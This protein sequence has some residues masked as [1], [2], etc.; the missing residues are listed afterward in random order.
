[1]AAAD[2]EAI[3]SPIAQMERELH[4]LE[5]DI[6][7]QPDGVRD[8]L[9][10]LLTQVRHDW[11]AT[12]EALDRTASAAREDLSTLRADLAI[13]RADLA[14]EMSE[15]REG[16]R[17]ALGDLVESWRAR[18]DHAKV[19]AELGRL[20]A[21]DEVNDDL[22]RAEDLWA[23]M[24]QRFERMGD[25][26]SELTGEVREDVRDLIEGIR[27]ALRDAGDRLAHSLDDEGRAAEE[28]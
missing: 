16:Y 4:T 21:R 8:R 12:R 26:A 18:L 17:S 25:E 6:A 14:A 19:Q 27:E 28:D 23:Q 9:E 11:S 7:G 13:V 10:A 22:E 5:S 3:T 20:E 15:S 1:M 2:D 24:R